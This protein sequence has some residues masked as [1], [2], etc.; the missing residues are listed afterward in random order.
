MSTARKAK[1]RKQQRKADDPARKQWLGFA[2]ILV[3][4]ISVV[5]AIVAMTAK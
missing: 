3:M 4:V 1:M 2:I 5:V